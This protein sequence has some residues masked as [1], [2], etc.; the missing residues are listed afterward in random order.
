MIQVYKVLH[1]VDNVDPANYFTRSASIH[2]HATRSA[3]TIAD[4]AESEAFGLVPEA[5]RSEIR[6]Q[7][8]TVRSVSKWNDLPKRVQESP[9]VNSFKTNF[10]NLIR[11]R[12]QMD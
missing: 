3:T 12:N 2:Q 9:S 11:A 6:R 5:A 10:D 7:F 1:K 8:F 4:N